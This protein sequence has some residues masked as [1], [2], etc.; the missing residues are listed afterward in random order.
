MVALNDDVIDALEESLPAVFAGVRL[1]QL[2]GGL[3]TWSAIRTRRC[4]GQIPEECFG[5]PFNLNAPTPMLKAPFLAWLRQRQPLQQIGGVSRIPAA[6]KFVA[7][8]RTR[9]TA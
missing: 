7:L 6:R 1:A 2:T 5:S 9:S 3:F 8:Q 4:R